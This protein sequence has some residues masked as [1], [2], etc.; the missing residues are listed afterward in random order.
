[1]FGNGAAIGMAFIQ[2]GQ[3]LT[4]E[5]RSLASVALF[6]VAP[7]SAPLIGV[8]PRL[9]IGANYTRESIPK[10]FASS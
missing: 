8:D 7:S 2:K 5:A 10:D 3:R 4:Q 9:A 1:M 6:A